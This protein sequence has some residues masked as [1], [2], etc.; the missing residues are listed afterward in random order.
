MENA[1]VDYCVD[2]S[3]NAV[4]VADRVV[5]GGFDEISCFGVK[6]GYF[7]SFLGRKM[8]F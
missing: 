6:L 5:Q 2:V 8:G 4:V 1:N 7:R 3:W